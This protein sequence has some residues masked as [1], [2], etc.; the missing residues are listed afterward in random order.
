MKTKQLVSVLYD[1]EGFGQPKI[2]LEQY[3]TPPD[4]AVAILDHIT[5]EID[6]EEILVADLG[7]GTGT[8]L[9]GSAL[10]G[11]SFAVGFDVDQQALQICRRNLEEKGLLNRCDLV[12]TDLRRKNSQIP[13]RMHGQ[14]D[15]VLTNPPFGTK[16]TQGTDVDFIEAGLLL[17]KPEGGRI[18]SLH[19]TSTRDFLLRRAKKWPGVRA[20]CR[21]QL[22]WNLDQSF[23]FHKKKSLD[24]DVDL[25]SFERI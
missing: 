7:C 3:S 25:F 24:I 15:I 8:L 11:C 1:M 20:E 2:E 6:M 4:I 10:V 5:Q 12:Q 17:A 23:G 16:N 14:F 9:V 21:A 19:K 13:E 22:R 18:F